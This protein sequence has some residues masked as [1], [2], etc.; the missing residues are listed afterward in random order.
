MD[1]RSPLIQ[2]CALSNY[3]TSPSAWFIVSK[4][5]LSD[6]F[7]HSVCA[8]LHIKTHTG[9]YKLK[10][11]I[12]ALKFSWASRDSL[13]RVTSQAVLCRYQLPSQ[14]PLSPTFWVAGPQFCLGHQYAQLHQ[15]TLFPNLP[16]ARGCQFYPR[17]RSR[18]GGWGRLFCSL[19]QRDRCCWI[20]LSYFFQLNLNL[21]SGAIAAIWDHKMKN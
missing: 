3:M 13:W 2:C 7:V 21:M 5:L 20:I 8:Y 6:D 10:M 1:I 14:L 11:A 9:N 12:R 16:A 17:G 4:A 18:L 15:T 19:E